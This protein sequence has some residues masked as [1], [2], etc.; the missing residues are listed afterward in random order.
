MS[1]RSP[2]STK[3]TAQQQYRVYNNVQGTGIHQSSGRFQEVQCSHKESTL[4]SV[5]PQTNTANM[6]H[7]RK[8]GKPEGQNHSVH[9]I[10]HN[11]H[12]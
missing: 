10:K 8:S 1:A 2:K 7:T 3:Q 4:V 12:L 9:N 11:R 5:R 6:R